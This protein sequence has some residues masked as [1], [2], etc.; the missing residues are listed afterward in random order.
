MAEGGDALDDQIGRRDLVEQQI[1]ALARGAADRLGAAGAHPE[2]RMRLLD[3]RR[4]DGDVVVVPQLAVIGKPALG[5]PRLADD[6]DRLVET[7]G[8]LLLRDAEAGKFI[9]PVALAD[10][11]I[12]PAVR[13]E[14][15][16]R[17]LFGDQHRVVPRQHHNRG[18]ETDLLGPRG[19]I[20]EQ[21]QRGGDLA[22]AG[23]MVLDQEHA[24]EAELFRS[25]DV[26][27]KFVIA[28]AVAGRAAAGAG[29]AEQSELHAFPPSCADRVSPS[30]QRHR[31]I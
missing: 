5:R 17:G 24:G 25:D 18:A 20:A 11:E 6:L 27:D 8:R 4:L 12:E 1:V 9:R 22:K 15:Q 28:V 2:R 13:Q 14:I 10:A 29:A 30:A 19:E 26:P 3:R 7:L 16:G 31:A 23:E 21:V